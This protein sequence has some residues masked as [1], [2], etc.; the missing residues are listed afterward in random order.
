MEK[1]ELFADELALIQD[2]CLREFCTY[3][4]R[5]VPAYFWTVAASASGKNHPE[6]AAGDGGLVRHTKAVVRCCVELLQLEKYKRLPQ[7]W[8]DYAIVACILHDCVKYGTKDEIN[9]EEYINHAQ[10]AALFIDEKWAC[11]YSTEQ[12]LDLTPAPELLTHA[13]ISHMGQW[14]VPATNK[15]ITILDEL[16]HMADYIASR[17]F[18]HFDFTAE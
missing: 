12:I 2:D 18:V 9:K 4:L 10:N 13:V 1:I 11:F 3:C 14:T 8:K 15:P 17:K 7:G 6:F 5:E 16:V